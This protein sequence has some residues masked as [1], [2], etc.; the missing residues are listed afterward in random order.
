MA[1]SSKK[2]SDA[3]SSRR[4]GETQQ[5]KQTKKQIAF[6]RKEAR[7]NRI[8]WL[9]VGVLGLIILLIL[10]YALI[11]EIMLKPAAPVAVVNGTKIQVG[12][13]QDLLQFRRYNTYGNI[14]NLQNELGTLDTTQE[15][16]E[17]LT[18]FYEQQLQQ[19]QT[20]LALAPQSVLDELIEDE[21]IREKAEESG[22]TVTDDEVTQTID[23]DLQRAAAPPPQVPI[24]DT[25]QIPAPTPV[26]QEQLDE[27]YQNALDNMGLS[28]KQFRTILKRSLYRT[29]LQDLLASQVMTTG[30]VVH[31][32]LVQTD[33]DEEATVALERIESGEDFGLVAR[34]VSTDTLTAENGGDL[35][36]VTTGQLSSRYGEDLDTTVFAMEVGQIEKVQG[37]GQFYLVLV[38]ERDENGPLPTEVVSLQQNSAL[39]DWLLERKESPE[40]QIERLLTPD[41]IPPDPFGGP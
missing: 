7:Q 27:I 28:D 41:Q 13:Y 39:S 29:E 24:S 8:I 1:K 35:G 16:S 37:N 22:L 32:Q 17:F 12:D 15:G 25:E 10:G 38:L 36:W 3:T 20:N 19:L 34:E 40:V 2:R 5:A 6:G 9:S 4:K 31:V 30:L 21:L 11:Q 23:E 14:V 33:T 18:S 26:P